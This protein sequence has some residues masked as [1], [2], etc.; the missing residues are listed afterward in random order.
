LV[1]FSFFW[2]L[3][4]FSLAEK[5]T[6]LG[7]EMMASDGMMRL[8]PMMSRMIRMVFMASPGNGER[9]VMLAPTSPGSVLSP[10]ARA[11]LRG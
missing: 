7:V 11:L 10:W 3:C 6:G 2:W 4:F 8:N 5:A 1:F 9:P